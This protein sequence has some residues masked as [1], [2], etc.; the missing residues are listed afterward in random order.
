M[1]SSFCFY[2]VDFSLEFDDILLSTPL[3][4]ISFF[5]ARAFRSA[6]YLLVYAL[7]SFFLVALRVMTFPLSI[8]FIVSHMFWYVV[9]SFSLNSKKSLIYFFIFSLNKLSLIRA[10]FSF[11][12]FVGFLLFLLLSKGSPNS[13]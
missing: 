5:C 8:A 9:P 2:L 12:V 3:G 7:F 1:Y 13:W 6:V 11:H 10:L 4:C